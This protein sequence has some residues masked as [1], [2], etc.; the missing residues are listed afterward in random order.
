MKMTKTFTVEYE[1][2][3]VGAKVVPTSPRCP[4]SMGKVYTVTKCIEP[5]CYGDDAIVFVEGHEFGVSTT[6]LREMLRTRPGHIK[7]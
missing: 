6:Y 5:L 2:F 3:T 7:G 1:F 4:L